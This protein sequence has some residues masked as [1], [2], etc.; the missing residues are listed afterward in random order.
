MVPIIIVDMVVSSIPTLARGHN[1][2]LSNQIIANITA[3]AK[4]KK[5]KKMNPKTKLNGINKYR[6]CI[7]SGTIYYYAL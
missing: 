5:P 2:T 4:P 3:K 7:L 1:T 6:I